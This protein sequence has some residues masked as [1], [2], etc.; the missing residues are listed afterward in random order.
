[1]QIEQ[2]LVIST[3]HISEEFD[4]F[5]TGN[6]K[7]RMELAIEKMDFGWNIAVLEETVPE[8]FD[9]ADFQQQY[10]TLQSL[11]RRK[12]V[13][14]IRLDGDAPVIDGLPQYEWA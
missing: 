4:R 14:R 11:G 2:V 13:D 1:M 9:N 8:A 10:E 6:R 3:A 12:W 5:L 7:R